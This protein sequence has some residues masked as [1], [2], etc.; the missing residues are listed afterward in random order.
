MKNMGGVGVLVES[1]LSIIVCGLG[2]NFMKSDQ[3]I[4]KF[5]KH[6]LPAMW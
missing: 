3:E 1:A 5:G 2:N 4:A 6:K